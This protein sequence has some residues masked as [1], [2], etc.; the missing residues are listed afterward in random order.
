MVTLC[1]DFAEMFSLHFIN[2]HLEIALIFFVN[3]L[4]GVPIYSGHLMTVFLHYSVSHP[5]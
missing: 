3:N 1:L 2:Q 4:E 5:F